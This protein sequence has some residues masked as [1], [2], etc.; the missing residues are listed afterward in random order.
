MGI[1]QEMEKIEAFSK[2]YYFSSSDIAAIQK[3]ADA[4]GVVN[5]D[6]IKTLDK[7]ISEILRV[8]ANGFD[9]ELDYDEE[10]LFDKE[11]EKLQKGFLEN[12]YQDYLKKLPRNAQGLTKNEYFTKAVEMVE[13]CANEEF[14]Q[15]NGW[16]KLYGIVLK[17][18]IKQNCKNMRQFLNSKEELGTT[19][20]DY[21]AAK[22][23]SEKVRKEEEYALLRFQK[24]FHGNKKE[25]DD[26]IKKTLNSDEYQSALKKYEK[27]KGLNK[28]RVDLEN[29]LEKM[30]KDENISPEQILQQEEKVKEMKAKCDKLREEHKEELALVNVIKD[31]VKMQ[32]SIRRVELAARQFK[33]AEESLLFY[34]DRIKKPDVVDDIKKCVNELLEK[35]NLRKGLHINT[36][37][38]NNMIKALKAVR[39][40]TPEKGSI[41]GTL[42]NLK[43]NTAAY[44]DAKNKQNRNRKNPSAL[45][46]TRLEFAGTLLFFSDEMMRTVD[47][48]RKYSDAFNTLDNYAKAKEGVQNKKEEPVKETKKQNEVLNRNF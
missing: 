10:E 28:E 37:E 16:R 46:N 25:V 35:E 9:D 11:W 45:R 41:K 5:I 47:Y 7:D 26:Y 19:L 18:K 44:L 27:V 34:H 48:V 39:D 8:S 2:K 32:K 20:D 3:L 42:L 12:S 15:T 43:E 36:K 38:Y 21:N 1:M 22:R 31:D 30:Q 24:R 33:V 23:I 4:E 29:E 14:V 40:W 13:N 6:Y 17:E